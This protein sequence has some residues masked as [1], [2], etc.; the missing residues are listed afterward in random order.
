MSTIVSVPLS[1]ALAPSYGSSNRLGFFY[2]Q[3]LYISLSRAKDLT[4]VPVYSSNDKHLLT[5]SY[6]MALSRGSVATHFTATGESGGGVAN[7]DDETLRGDESFF[8]RTNF[9]N[10]INKK[11]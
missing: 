10:Q 5:A 1:G 6:R 7:H 8:A 4:I 3:P 2:A 11:H 9:N